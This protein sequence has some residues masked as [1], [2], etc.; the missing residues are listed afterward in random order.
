VMDSIISLSVICQ[1]KKDNLSFENSFEL[2]NSFE[3]NVN[4]YV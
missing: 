3:G 1:D 4:P 2:Y